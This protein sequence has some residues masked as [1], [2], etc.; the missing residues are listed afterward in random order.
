MIKKYLA[1]FIVFVSFC[2]Y[3][4]Q[5][6]QFT[7]FMFNR[8]FYNPGHTGL[9]EAICVTAF[10]RTQWAGFENAPETQTITLDAPV[11]F[12]AGGLGVNFF[13]DQI[14]F[15]DNINFSLSYAYHLPLGD[16][17]LGI[18]VRADLLNSA[19]LQPEWITPSGQPPGNDGS[20]ARPGANGIA[21]DAAFGVHYKSEKVNFGVSSVRMIEAETELQNGANGVTQFRGKRTYLMNGNYRIDVENTNIAIIPGFFLKSDFVRTQADINVMAMIDN[22]FWGGLSYRLTDAFAIMAGAQIAESLALGYSYD[23]TT[24]NLSAVSNGSH[25]VFLRYCFKIDIPPREIGK[26]RNVRFL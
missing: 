16:G 22:K 9:G 23:L 6:I 24:S 7:Q 19:L 20:I 13:R 17:V 15:F 4:Q 10:H 25:E 18:G 3:G 26:Y 14:G 11:K 21:F 1:V 5:E 12:L 8:T 2:A